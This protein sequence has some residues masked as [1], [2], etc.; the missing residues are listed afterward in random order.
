MTNYLFDTMILVAIICQK[1]VPEKWYCIW[2]QIQ[3]KTKKLLLF[4]PLIAEV[5]YQ[6]IKIKQ[7]HFVKQDI[8]KIKGLPCTSI[9]KLDDN[10]SFKAGKIHYQSQNI[11]L[12][13]AFSLC[14]AERYKAI[15]F[16]TDYS[17]KKSAEKLN[18]KTSYL[19]KEELGY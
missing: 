7:E 10:L 5:F 13:D 1:K 8:L 17:L 19:P 3:E 16:T 9:I 15:I 2:Q 11:S 18:I 4:E 12:V 6:L 14:I